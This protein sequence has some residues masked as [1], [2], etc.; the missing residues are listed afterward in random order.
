MLKSLLVRVCNN[1][2]LLNML[3]LDEPELVLF[4]KDGTIIDIHHYWATMIGIRSDYIAEKYF[5]DVENVDEIKLRLKSAMGVDLQ[6][7]RIKPDGP[8]GIK[9]RPFIV[10]VAT[11]VIVDEGIYVSEDNIEAIFKQVDSYTESNLK[12]LLKLLPGVPELLDKLDRCSIKAAIV[13]T[14]IT[15]R[16]AKAMQELNIDKYFVSI[17]GGDAVKNTKPAADLAVLV[18]DELGIAAEK[19]VVVGDHPVDIEMGL[20]AGITTNI[21]VLTGLSNASR[22]ENLDCSVIDDLTRIEVRC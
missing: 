12:P 15:N 17:K 9:P 16:A 19:C 21:G 6:S 3:T 14:D 18:M 1:I 10:K 11:D 4:D 8:V 7:G 22:F 20:N 13:S 5:V 2:C